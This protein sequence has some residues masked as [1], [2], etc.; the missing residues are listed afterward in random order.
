MD[1]TTDFFD[2]AELLG[3]WDHVPSAHVKKLHT[4]SFQLC[5]RST[6][7]NWMVL[8]NSAL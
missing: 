8:S 4:A 6:T 1:R 3:I 2:D 5:P 7:V